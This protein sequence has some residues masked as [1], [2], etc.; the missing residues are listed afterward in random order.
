MEL[1]K[2]NAIKYVLNLIPLYNFQFVLVLFL[3]CSILSFIIDVFAE[4]KNTLIENVIGGVLFGF[5]L[6]VMIWV[7]LYAL[8]SRMS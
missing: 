8:K 3:C 7:L 4:E 6:A 2:V 5:I 1:I